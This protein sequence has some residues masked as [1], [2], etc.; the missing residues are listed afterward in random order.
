[1]QSAKMADKGTAKNA[2]MQEKGIKTLFLMPFFSLLE[3][4]IGC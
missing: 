1:M 2:N 4:E 3:V